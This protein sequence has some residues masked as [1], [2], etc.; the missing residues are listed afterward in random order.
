MNEGP[1]LTWYPNPLP[2]RYLI[3]LLINFIGCL[4]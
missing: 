3:L 4:W 1:P 2:C